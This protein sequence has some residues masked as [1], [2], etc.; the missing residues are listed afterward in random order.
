VLK[1][2]FHFL[3]IEIMAN[4]SNTNASKYTEQEQDIINDANRLNNL[5]INYLKKN[6]NSYR[7]SGSSYGSSGS[8]YELSYGSSYRSSIN[9]IGECMTHSYFC[10]N[11]STIQS[12][13]K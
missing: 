3:E 12:I 1:Q 4:Y 13:V 10:S 7:L 11:G 5:H 9:N 2:L 6:I 8:S